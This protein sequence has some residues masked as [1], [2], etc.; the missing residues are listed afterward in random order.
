[1]APFFFVLSSLLV[2]LALAA[3]AWA[4]GLLAESWLAAGEDHPWPAGFRLA[5]G[6]ACLSQLLLGLAL[7]GQLR[8]ETVALLGL[9]PIVAAIVRWRRLPPALA[10]FGSKACVLLGMCALPLFVLALYPPLGFDQTLYHLP[11]SRAFAETGGLP[12]LADL[13]FPVFP[14]LA[15]VLQAAIWLASSEIATQ[16]AGV[17]SLLACLCLLTAWAGAKAGRGAGHFATAMVYGSPCAVYLA[18]CGYLE[19]VLALFVL[20]ALYAAEQSEHNGRA[21]WAGLAGLLA[22]SAAA[23]KYIG[24][25]FLPIALLWLLRRVSWRSQWRQVGSYI[26]AALLAAGPTYAR[27]VALTG[28]PLFPFYSNIFGTSSY[29]EEQMFPRGFGRLRGVATLFWDL[30]FRRDAVGHLPHYSPAFLLALPC[31]FLALRSEALRRPALTAL[32]FL[33]LAPIHGHYFLSIAPIWALLT[34]VLLARWVGTEPSLRRRVFG[35]ATVVLAL[36]GPLYAIYRVERL[37]LPPASEE[38]RQALLREQLPLYPAFTFLNRQIPLPKVFAAGPMVA[39]MTY[40]YRG[41]LFGDVNGNESVPQVA[42]RTAQLGG[43]A[44]ALREI[45]AEMILIEKDQRQ[46]L[47]SAEEDAADLELVYEDDAARVYRVRSPASEP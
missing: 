9:L 26:G 30:I 41:R 31:A 22:G 39:R 28:N 23:C 40:Y 13:R 5:A 17:F 7:V 44:E 37:G 34:G 21:S 42:A 2:L 29:T 14:A 3:T 45:P 20:G 32:L 1:M 8:F 43:L 25:F 12:Y 16:Q 19:P 15:E 10:G 46:W 27:I 11:M 36:G 47:D 24:L 33:L 4:A 38:G 35:A 6:L 18:S